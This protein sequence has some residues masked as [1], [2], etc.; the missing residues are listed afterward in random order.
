MCPLGPTGG[1]HPK[2]GC[3]GQSRKWQ[4][5]VRR[6]L[7]QVQNTIHPKVGCRYTPACAA[8]IAWDDLDDAIPVLRPPDTDHSPGSAARTWAGINADSRHTTATVRI[9]TMRRASAR[10][11]R[12][13]RS[14][15]SA[16]RRAQLCFHRQRGSNRERRLPEY[17]GRSEQ[18]VLEME[19]N[20][21]SGTLSLRVEGSVCTTSGIP[22]CM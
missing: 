5:G 21:D 16:T 11:P 7:N 4:S 9:T 18:T 13:R 19:V 1:S 12:G 10:T 6:R 22:D 17:A 8:G 3:P 15:R 2:S 14:S 20:G